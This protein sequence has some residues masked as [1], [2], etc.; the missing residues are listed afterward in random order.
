MSLTR[1]R[2]I[3][4]VLTGAVL[5]AG[6]VGVTATAAHAADLGYDRVKL[7]GN[8]TDFGRSWDS[9]G[10]PLNGG[11]LFWELNN[12]EVEAD[13]EGYLYM[14]NAAGDCAK[15]QLE[16]HDDNH[17][18]LAVDESPR[19]CT[20]SNSK[21][22]FFINEEERHQFTTHVVIRLLEDNGADGD[23]VTVSSGTYDVGN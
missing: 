14:K 20:Q 15:I 11:Y 6:L 18:V 4:T 10:A 12:G 2:P 16:Y 8:E 1:P 23:Y 13:L 9:F 5:A 21:V 19:Y 17:D 3:P 7:T 22:Q